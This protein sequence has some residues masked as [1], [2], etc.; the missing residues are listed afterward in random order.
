MRTSTSV[1]FTST[2]KRG[3]IRRRIL[4]AAAI[5][6]IATGTVRMAEAKPWARETAQLQSASRKKN[7]REIL[8]AMADSQVISGSG[9]QAWVPGG[10]LGPSKS[11]G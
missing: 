8:R 4:T 10:Y 9:R 3:S 6:Q 2:R 11:W 1:R 7:A 5:F